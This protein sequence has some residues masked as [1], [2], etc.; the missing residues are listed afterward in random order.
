MQKNMRYIE[1]TSL[2]LLIIG[3]TFKYFELLG[4]NTYQQSAVKL[5]KEISNNWIL[6]AFHGWSR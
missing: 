6:N 1:K 5:S 2:A 3:L 4:G